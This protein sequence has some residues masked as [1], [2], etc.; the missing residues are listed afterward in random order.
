MPRASAI[1][2]GSAHRV[3]PYSATRYEI[4]GT[5]PDHTEQIGNVVPVNLAKSLV[6]SL[7]T[8]EF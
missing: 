8:D 7:L 4:A 2:P 5:K 3:W 6:K 1:T